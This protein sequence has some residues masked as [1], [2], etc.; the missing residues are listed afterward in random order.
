MTASLA[1]IIVLGCALLGA[2]AYMEW[3]GAWSL[4]AHRDPARHPSC[5]HLNLARRHERPTCWW[6][7]HQFRRPA[8]RGWIR[9]TERGLG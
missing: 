4:L 8:A 7:Y 2:T 3:V 1:V 5:G 9:P 6:C